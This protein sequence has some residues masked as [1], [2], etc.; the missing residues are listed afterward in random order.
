MGEQYDFS[1]DLLSPLK[2]YKLLLF[3]KNNFAPAFNPLQP[4]V[5]K[6]DLPLHDDKYNLWNHFETAIFLSLCLLHAC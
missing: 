3:T 4:S 6:V 1:P 5:P 2:N